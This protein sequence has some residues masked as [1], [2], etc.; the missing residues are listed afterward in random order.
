MRAEGDGEEVLLYDNVIIRRAAIRAEGI[1]RSIIFGFPFEAVATEPERN[2]LMDLSLSWL[3]DL[4]DVDGDAEAVL[5]NE[6]SLAQ[7]YP[8]P[9][10]PSTSIA[11]TLPHRSDVSIAVFDLMGREVARLASGTMDAGVHEVTWRAADVPSGVYFYRMEAA[12]FKAT[13]KMVL[14][15]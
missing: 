12:S 3:M 8:N 10:N 7:N 9:F 13:R 4:T 2:Q 1:H 14:V 6:F 5:P 11:F 15:K